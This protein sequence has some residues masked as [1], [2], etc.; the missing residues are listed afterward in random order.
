MLSCTAGGANLTTMQSHYRS[1]KGA[2]SSDRGG[3][4]RALAKAKSRRR[5]GN[6]YNF[7]DHIEALLESLK[8]RSIPSIGP[9]P[10][11]TCFHYPGQQTSGT[12][13]QDGAGGQCRSDSRKESESE[14]ADSRLQG[15]EANLPGSDLLGT[16]PIQRWKKFYRKFGS[17]DYKAHSGNY[18]THYGAGTGR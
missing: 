9:F 15:F 2:V 1:L 8:H 5:C 7:A 11:R 12:G 3:I 14:A 18:A 16:V 17:D 6:S 4:C 10:R 13:W